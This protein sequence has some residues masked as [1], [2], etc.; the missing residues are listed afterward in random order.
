MY[1]KII[2]I[3]I[4]PFMYAFDVS[5][6]GGS[7]VKAAI[8]SPKSMITVSNNYKSN[9]LY[10][11]LAN[12]LSTI[13]NISDNASL[14][15]G[16]IRDVKDSCDTIVSHLS[17]SLSNK[18]SNLSTSLDNGLDKVES[19]FTGVHNASNSAL[20][21]VFD[22]NYT[23]NMKDIDTEEREEFIDIS[24]NN[25]I[26][27]YIPHTTDTLSKLST[28]QKAINASNNSVIADLAIS[29][30]RYLFQDKLSQVS[31]VAQATNKALDSGRGVVKY[32]KKGLESVK[33]FFGIK[34]KKTNIDMVEGIKTNDTTITVTNNS[35][36][37]KE[38]KT[39]FK[40]NFFGFKK[41][42]D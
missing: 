5:S 27:S 1:M 16:D 3:S 8:S 26:P 7:L 10:N 17:P 22:A 34:T 28:A 31:A 35:S 41:K 2:L 18:M 37:K 12:P 29:S 19:A 20:D 42:S 23:H 30:V 14:L 15:V 39:G 25:N 4:T 6:V 33:N 21:Y 9:Q 38:Q 13:S 36:T 24:M 40:F 32:I 11:S